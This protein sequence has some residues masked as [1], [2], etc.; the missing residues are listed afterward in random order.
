[1]KRRRSVEL[2][3]PSGA[4]PCSWTSMRFSGL[5]SERVSA[6]AVL[7]AWILLVFLLQQAAEGVRRFFRGLALGPLS[8]LRS[9]GLHVR[10]DL[11]VFH[12]AGDVDGNGDPPLIVGEEIQ[13]ARSH[14]LD[15]EPLTGSRERK[16]EID[17]TFEAHRTLQI[18]AGG[19]PLS[20]RKRPPLAG[21][22]PA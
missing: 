9:Q 1:M 17:G 22:F 15:P 7:I 8:R 6:G 18:E 5:R 16:V 10:A 20:S 2:R 13:S 11:G 19:A 4:N 21:V 14:P 3:L 12:G